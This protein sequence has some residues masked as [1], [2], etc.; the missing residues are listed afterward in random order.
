MTLLKTRE[1]PK[2]IIGG[3]QVSLVH[4]RTIVIEI[5]NG[6]Y[7]TNT[8]ISS[9]LID[10]N[11]NAP[12]LTSI[13][14]QSVAFKYLLPFTDNI[15]RDDLRNW[16]KE[17]ISYYKELLWDSYKSEQYEDIDI[18]DL[19]G[20]YFAGNVALMYNC[21]KDYTSKHREMCKSSY[22]FLWDKRLRVSQSMLDPLLL[23][24]AKQVLEYA[25][26][27]H[28]V[29][30]YVTDKDN[31]V[32]RALKLIPKEYEPA[33]QTFTVYKYLQGFLGDIEND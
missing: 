31:A 1:W 10:I 29:C 21:M 19:E 13:V 25:K 24:E 23:E 5:N 27:K 26:K 16:S 22:Q 6:T 3:A 33:E 30:S 12:R 32:I 2:T 28:H 17:V 7:N 4:F 8:D 14:L 18:S 20:L 9:L 15:T 11:S